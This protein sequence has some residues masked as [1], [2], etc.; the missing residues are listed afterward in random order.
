MSPLEQN[1]VTSVVAGA[2]SGA[3]GGE[4]FSADGHPTISKSQES[5]ALGNP[6]FLIKARMQVNKTRIPP[7][8][9]IFTLYFFYQAYSYSPALPVGTQRHYKNSFDAL[10]TILRKD[11]PRGLLLFYGQLWD[12]RWAKVVE[13]HN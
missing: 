2:S 6:L 10:S 3:V 12:L 9:F 13:T 7:V 8:P 1:T 4:S 5:A 11:G